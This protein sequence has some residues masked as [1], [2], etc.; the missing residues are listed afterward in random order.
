MNRAIRREGGGGGG[1]T[2]EIMAFYCIN[3]LFTV[4]D[5]HCNF[6]IFNRFILLLVQWNP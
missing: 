3:K 6:Q 1:D 4:L 5:M 2:K